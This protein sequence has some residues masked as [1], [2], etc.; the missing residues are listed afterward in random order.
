MGKEGWHC[1]FLTKI[2]KYSPIS[3]DH[4]SYRKHVDVFWFDFGCFDN[5]NMYLID[6]D[7]LKEAL[8]IDIENNNLDICPYFD[9][10][11]VFELADKLPD[12]IDLNENK[13]WVANIEDVENGFLVEKKY[14]GILPKS[15]MEQKEHGGAWVVHIPNNLGNGAEEKAET[16][17][18]RNIPDVSFDDIGGLEKTI[19]EI[20]EIIELPVKQ[21]E[22]FKYLGITPHKG[23]LL[24]GPP[25]C[26]KTLIAKAIASEIKAHFI[27]IKGSEL[28]GKYI[29]QSEENLRKVFEE[30]RDYEPSIIF[31]D[32]I[33][34]IA[35]TRSAQ[36]SIRHSSQFVNQLLTLMDGVEDYGNIRII[37]STN[38]KE[39]LD[40]AV[41]R[42]G[43]FD[44]NIKIEKPTKAGCQAIF[45]IYTKKMPIANI[46][47]EKYAEKLYGKTGADIA[48]II[49]EGAYNCIRRN[50]NVKKAIEED[51]KINFYGFVVTEEDLD[52][53]IETL[54]QNALERTR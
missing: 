8:R 33:D 38:R 20:R 42:P 48:F 21:P 4:Y 9:R 45:K 7:S 12:K 16:S 28:F 2:N 32:E 17:S 26:G 37:A 5:E 24:Y 51:R 34:A 50:V 54:K 49:K 14:V 30:A 44:R 6:K 27:S 10:N 47:V 13:D 1:K 40:E 39:L 23:I 46:N 52:K 31:F 3:W 18:G 36:E 25:G 35:Q 43:R 41:L 29:G 22:L 53:G 19:E 11:I 15:I